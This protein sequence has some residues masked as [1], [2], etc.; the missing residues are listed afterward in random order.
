[1]STRKTLI[2]KK[3][4]KDAIL[5]GRKTSTIRLRTDLKAGDEAYIVVGG[6]KLGIAKITAVNKKRL[7]DL[8]HRDAKRDG[9]ANVRELIRALKKHYK[10]VRPWTEVSI[11]HFKL[12][13]GRSEES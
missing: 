2:F 11:I 12:K 5:S 8:S 10:D 4:Y 6:T 9:F 7:S 3:E 13:R 1:M